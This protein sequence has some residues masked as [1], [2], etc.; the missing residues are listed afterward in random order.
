LVSKKLNLKKA[1]LHLVTDQ[2]RFGSIISKYE[3]KA[4]ALLEFTKIVGGADENVELQ[5]SF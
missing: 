3:I 1:D 2:S 4:P 5:F